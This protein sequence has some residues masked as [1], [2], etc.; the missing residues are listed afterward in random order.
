[1]FLPSQFG[2]VPRSAPVRKQQ[3]PPVL[4]S[5][6]L[7]SF[8]SFSCSLPDFSVASSLGRLLCSPLDCRAVSPRRL[9]SAP[10]SSIASDST[11]GSIYS[12]SSFLCVRVSRFLWCEF[13]QS[14][15]VLFARLQCCEPQAAQSD[16]VGSIA[17]S[18]H[19]DLLRLWSPVQLGECADFL[20]CSRSEDPTLA[21]QGEP[22]VSCRKHLRYKGF[23][24]CT[25]I[26]SL[27]ISCWV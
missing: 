10:V 17:F 11:V 14:T 21:D 20:S 16:S 15:L 13:Y 9:L 5:L 7:P 19:L 8:G 3:L 27:R 12:D 4:E 2:F 22:C 25:P 1:V 26:Y 24:P 6:L 23:G 18:S